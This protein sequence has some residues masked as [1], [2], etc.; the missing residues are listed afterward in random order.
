MKDGSDYFYFHMEAPD[1][2]GHQGDIEHKVLSIE[3]IDAKVVGP[4]CDAL[5]TAKVPFSVL[6]MRDHPTPLKLKTHTADSVPFIL[7]VP[8]DEKEG[9]AATMNEKTAEASGVYDP[10]WRDLISKF[11]GGKH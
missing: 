10:G 1:E 3:L 5:R 2:C 11:L 6:I 9:S 8:H 7:Y 4:V